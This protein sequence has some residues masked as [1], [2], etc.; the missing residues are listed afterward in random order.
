MH[1]LLGV[2]AT[3]ADDVLHGLLPTLSAAARE[4]D[5]VSRRRQHRGHR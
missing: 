4:H 2:V 5:V 1:A 3:H